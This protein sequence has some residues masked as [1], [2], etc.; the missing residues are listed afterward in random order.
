MFRSKIKKCVMWLIFPILA[1]G[2]TYCNLQEE[3]SQE[4]LFFSPI[5]LKQAPQLAYKHRQDLEAFDYLIRSNWYNERA[6]L[7]GFLPQ[8]SIFADTGKSSEPGIT[9]SG[10]APFPKE[11]I[12]INISQLVFSYDGPMFQYKIAQED[13]HISRAQKDQLENL[14]RINSENSFLEL[15]KELLRHE[16]IKHLDDSS[17]QTFDKDLQRNEVGFL[18]I[19]QWDS[20][21]AIY[22]QDKT[23]VEN[24]PNDLQAALSKLRREVNTDINPHAIS[25]NYKNIEDIT[26]LSMQDY[27]KLALGNRPELD[28][29]HHRIKQAEYSNRYY[30]YRY[31]PELKFGAQIRKS[32]LLACPPATIQSGETEIPFDNTPLVWNIA[33]QATWNFDGLSS[34]NT[35]K[36]FQDLSTTVMLQK[37]DLELNILK[38]VEVTYNNLAN[39]IHL[40]QPAERKYEAAKSQ[41]ETVQ[42]AYDVGL[43]ALF[44]Y[45][46]AKLN[47]KQAEFDL[48]SLKIDIRKNYQGLLFLCGFPNGPSGTTVKRC[49]CKKCQCFVKK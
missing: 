1:S 24:Y 30:K 16:V 35:S 19:A 8:I 17:Q 36:K 20:A 37:R 31:I 6:A 2:T 10:L 7:G 12:T 5:T 25:L 3:T 45:K 4:Y 44:E 14:I 13:T 34:Y 43:A 47:Y 29:Q 9:G 27:Q 46:Q 39:L 28:E 38:D 41:L 15:K 49:P 18:N 22:S 23:N 40:L 42:K 21:R 33:L 26:L 48:I 32:R 11:S